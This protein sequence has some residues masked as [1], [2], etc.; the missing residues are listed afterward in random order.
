M[1][2]G[3]PILAML[4][5]AGS[6]VVTEANCGIVADAGDYIQL[7]KNVLKSY[8]LSNEKLKDYGS[9]ASKY[10]IK[11]YSKEKIINNFIELV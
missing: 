2:S 6:K 1:A 3:K 4:N 7:A 8:N 11:N 10:Y 5:G 9:N